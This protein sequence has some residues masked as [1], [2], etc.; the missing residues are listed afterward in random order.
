MALLIDP[1]IWPAHGT[2]FAHLVSD[3]SLAEL[4]AFADR[5][6]LSERA[7]DGDHYD[8]PAHRHAELVA[9]GARSVSGRELIRRLRAS[10]LRIPARDRPE[11]LRRSLHAAWH[12]VAA[13]AGL[14]ERTTGSGAD[15]NTH[16]GSP[17]RT[18]AGHQISAGAGPQIGA[19][20]IE[21]WAQPHRRYH[22]LRHLR[23]VLVALDLL[24]EPHPPPVEVALAAWFHDAV[25][26]G[27]AGEDEEASANLA[28]SQLTSAHLPAGTVNEV[29]RLVLLTRTHSPE[30]GDHRGALL[31]DAD[32]A[33]LGRDEPGYRRYTRDVRAEYAHVPEAGFIK[34]R[35]AVVG[36]LLGLDPLYRT[37]RG[38]HL[39]QER[40][41]ANLR[42]E[43][44][45]LS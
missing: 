42:A 18:T 23:D 33:V 30:P 7:F 43:L 12:Q 41:R 15:G 37:D 8:V 34:G 1:P 20:L 3:E 35:T 6:G 31:C 45:D 22:D 10:G 4:H 36:H 11:A 13:R 29:S 19:D 17:S 5:A 28:R 16:P 40:A 26:A 14:P 38:R 21:R 25:Y 9:L 27:V 2:T 24:C 32:L 44:S 39:W